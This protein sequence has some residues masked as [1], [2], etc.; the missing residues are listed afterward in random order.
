MLSSWT[1]GG[2][3]ISNPNNLVE[4]LLLPTGG[5]IRQDRVLLDKL[6]GMYIQP[7]SPTFPGGKSY[8]R[9]YD[10]N[11]FVELSI[12][13]YD[14]SG[15]ISVGTPVIGTAENFNIIKVT[16]KSQIINQVLNASKKYEIRTSLVLGDGE[17]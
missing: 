4:T 14:S 8:L 2:E 3:V 17:L 16:D 5:L 12:I 9:P 13:S 6:G 11:E 1:I 10:Q 7:G 15:N